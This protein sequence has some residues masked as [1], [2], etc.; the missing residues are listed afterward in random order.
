MKHSGDV[1]GM[2]KP[3]GTGPFKVTA[4][5]DH[6]CRLEAFSSY[7][8]GRAHM[9]RVDIL[10]IPWSASAKMDDSQDIETPFFHL[11]HNPSSSAGADWTQISAGVMVH[12][13]LTCNTQKTGPLND[14][15]VKHT[16]SHALL[17][18]IEM[19]DMEIT[20]KS[21]RLILVR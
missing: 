3:V 15:E 4:W 5:D 10:Q 11:V 7:F 12:K 8:Q 16:F 17:A 13:L 6:L 20:L 9:D 19:T 18:C 1:H 14:P 2:Q 21:W